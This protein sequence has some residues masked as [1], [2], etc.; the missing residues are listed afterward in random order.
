MT[1]ESGDPIFAN[2]IMHQRRHSALKNW[3]ALKKWRDSA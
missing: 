2:E 3:R 1:G